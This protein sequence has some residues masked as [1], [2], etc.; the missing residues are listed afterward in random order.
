MKKLLV[1][2]A[3]LLLAAVPALA[4]DYTVTLN[5]G[6][7]TTTT[8]ARTESN[9]AACA[10]VG[11][12]ASCT[13]AQADAAVAAAAAEVP[14]RTLPSV[15]VMSNNSKYVNS[16][17]NAEL[18]RIKTVQKAADKNSFDKARDTATQA[19]KDAACVALGLTAGCL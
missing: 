2:L 6:Q 13:Q 5:A 16:L 3:L 19:Q 17:V 18:A 15:N 8:R 9:T 4:A 7:E 11:L 12:P 14:P 1:V 10:L